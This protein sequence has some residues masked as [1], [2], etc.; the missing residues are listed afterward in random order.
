MPALYLL[1]VGMS[2]EMVGVFVQQVLADQ[3]MAPGFRSAVLL[4]AGVTTAYLCVQFLFMGALQFLKPTRSR[5]VYICESLSQ[6][7]ALLLLP[8]ILRVSVVWPHPLMKEVEPAVYAGLF[9]VA[10]GFF[11]LVT[12]F[13]ALRGVAGTRIT[14]LFWVTTGGASGAAAYFC[15]LAWL[16]VMSAARPSVTDEAGWYVAG[17]EW[18]L[19]REVPEGAVIRAPVEPYPNQCLVFRLSNLPPSGEELTPLERVFVTVNLEGKETTR[20][21][22]RVALERSGWSELRVPPNRIPAETKLCSVTW[23]VTAEPRWS[24]LT[25]LR[26]AASGRRKLLI[27]GPYQCETT[28]PD[29]SPNL[30]LIVVD[31]LGT[32]HI[33][34]LG[35]AEGTTPNLDRFIMS[36]TVFPNAYTPS[37]EPVAA[38]MTVLTGVNPLRHGFLGT[39]RGPLSA[40]IKT[41]GELLDKAHYAT[42]AFSDDRSEARE[43]S[44]KA[45]SLE[46]G[47][48]S[49][50]FATDT[51]PGDVLDRARG[52]IDQHADIKFM[53]T[54][55]LES[56]FHRRELTPAVNPTLNIQQDLAEFDRRLGGFLQYLR[57]H[58]LRK[59]T[60]IVL[61]SAHGGGMPGSGDELTEEV[62]RVPI[63]LCGPGLK[64]EIRVEPV[65]LQDIAPTVLRLAGREAPSACEGR[66]LS[67]APREQEPIS[68]TG[69]PLKLS[70]RSQRW[71][72]T[73]QMDFHPFGA[74]QR[75]WTGTVELYDLSKTKSGAELRNIASGNPNTVGG[76]RTKLEAYLDRQAAAYA[77]THK[78]ET[79][80]TPETS[81]VTGKS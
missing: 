7:A 76:F 66:D 61:T 28:A 43:P 73:W 36:S 72:F 63:M 64:R 21:A 74:N 54:I 4:A 52:W 41:V 57:D 79:A 26:P 42:A 62:L 68:M 53:V 44:N 71:R 65:A 51:H 27:S 56:F 10:H 67:Q 48:Q 46:R 25:G 20:V 6:L 31:G 3:G 12:F 1:S 33:S 59:R 58:E 45:S 35:K 2:A 75:P 14:S 15:A 70:L 5:G 40:E 9:A 50:D 39:R 22:Q 77:A 81:G 8:Y 18:S 47:I 29:T 13:A 23:G 24:A 55:R 34:S 69:V 78:P 38:S 49:L 80:A 19:A 32:D 30:V 16:D 37:P 11:K 60:C 17:S